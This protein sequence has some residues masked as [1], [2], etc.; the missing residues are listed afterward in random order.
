MKTDL[1][2]GLRLERGL[3]DL[4]PVETAGRCEVPLFKNLKK[5]SGRE[6]AGGRWILGEDTRQVA[7]QMSSRNRTRRDDGS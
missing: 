7:W 3:E 4:H 6:S 1:E 5:Q 2:K